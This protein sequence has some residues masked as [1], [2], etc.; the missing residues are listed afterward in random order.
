MKQVVLGFFL[1]LFGT[2]AEAQSTDGISHSISGTRNLTPIACT[3]VSAP[4][5]RPLTD[6]AGNK[7]SFGAPVTTN[8]LH[9]F[10]V[11]KNGVP[12]AGGA[13][14]LV[15]DL[16]GVSLVDSPPGNLWTPTA[17]G[18]VQASAPACGQIP[19]AAVIGAVQ[20]LP[21]S[22]Y[23]P[24]GYV[25]TF[26]DEFASLNT[27]SSGPGPHVDGVLWYN[28]NVQGDIQPSV[29]GQSGQMYPTRGPGGVP[30][31]PFS[32][33]PAGGLD[34]SL[35]LSGNMWNSGQPDSMANNG[36]GF[37]QQYGY[38][39]MSAQL[40]ASP[41]TWPGFWMR[42]L[43]PGTNNGEIDIM[44]AYTQFQTTYCATL[45]DWNNP[46]NSITLGCQH[47][48]P[49]NLTAGYHVYSMLWTPTMV[50]FYCDGIMIGQNPPLLPAMGGPYYLIFD[51]GIGGGFDTSATASPSVM[52]IKYIR[53]YRQGP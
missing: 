40:P 13:A 49:F 30:I 8:G 41:G 31:N 3:T 52:K 6:A 18:W 17:T 11:L 42:P 26:N 37:A 5:P 43:H 51:L 15:T 34:L 48:L 21:D 39:E 20:R 50:S 4:D 46:K 9:D 38:F 44:E 23:V 22:P 36:I 25:L 27:I 28:G 12:F 16:N 1:A 24:P 35:T 32:L 33:D 47:V 7:W 19:S 53:A 2:L 29:A 14:A 10:Y 45:H